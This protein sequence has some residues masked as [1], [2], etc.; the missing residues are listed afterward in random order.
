[1]LAKFGYCLGEGFFSFSIQYNNCWQQFWHNSRFLNL[2]F[3]HLSLLLGNIS[4]NFDILGKGHLAKLS[5]ILLYILC[6]YQF[7]VYFLTLLLYF[8]MLYF[9]IHCTFL[10]RLMIRFGEYIH[11]FILN[12]AP[13]IILRELLLR[14]NV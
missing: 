1:M 9:K 3:W 4:K 2:R 7:I 5:L 10:E 11:I 12:V 6:K 13:K 8:Y 14:T